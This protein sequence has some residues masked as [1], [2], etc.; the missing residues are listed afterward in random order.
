MHERRLLRTDLRRPADVYAGSKSS[1]QISE[2]HRYDSHLLND[3]EDTQLS[4]RI[5]V[6]LNLDRSKT[7]ASTPSD[8]TPATTVTAKCPVPQPIAQEPYETD[9]AFMLEYAV[10]TLR[11]RER[12]ES[13]GILRRNEYMPA[14][15]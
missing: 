3:L 8:S 2:R 11:P 13:T 9:I 10:D 1:V 5:F 12:K 14:V 4:H 7:S 6:A 15:F